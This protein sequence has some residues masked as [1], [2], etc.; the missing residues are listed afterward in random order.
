MAKAKK[1]VKAKEKPKQYLTCDC[2]KCVRKWGIR[3]KE[4]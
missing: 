1:K 3:G 4:Q 2:A